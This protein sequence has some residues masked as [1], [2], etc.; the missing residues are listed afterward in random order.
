MH[1]TYDREGGWVCRRALPGFGHLVSAYF[2]STS[3]GPVLY[4]GFRI[5]ARKG[6]GRRR[7]RLWTLWTRKGRLRACRNLRE[8]LTSRDRVDR[9]ESID[10]GVDV[11]RDRVDRVAHSTAFASR[12]AKAR[13]GRGVDGRGRGMKRPGVVSGKA[14]DSTTASTSTGARAT[15]ATK[16]GDGAKG[17][18]ITNAR[19]SS[20]GLLAR[21]LGD[22]KA[23]NE[24]RKRTVA[25]TG[26]RSVTRDEVVSR[27]AE[28]S[29]ARRRFEDEVRGRL[30]R[31]VGATASEEAFCEFAPMEKQWRS[32]VHEIA[33][34][35][36]MFSES[37]EVGDDGDKFVIVHKREPRGEDAGEAAR[38]AT[39]ARE[40]AMKPSRKGEALSDKAPTFAGDDVELTVVGTVKRD[41]RS[42]EETIAD[43]RKAKE[44]KHDES[45]IR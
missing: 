13:G 37:V 44:A 39:A 2:P 5:G 12:D 15:T 36:K 35:M 45:Q 32:V 8:V 11:A 18:K 10:T 6:R 20:G 17:T 24:A 40:R 1:R 25:A 23:S 19:R 41:L 21:I 4:V 26:G 27:G 38:D 3:G 7:G 14:T 31:E 43:M 29:E 9:L 28:A 16:R 30:A 22:V 33:A 42:V 34:E